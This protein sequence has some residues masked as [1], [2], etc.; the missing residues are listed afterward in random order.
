MIC[1][2]SSH[3]FCAGADHVCGILHL[4]LAFS[5]VGVFALE[6]LRQESEG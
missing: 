3:V 6:F 5:V 4:R 1:P 2:Q